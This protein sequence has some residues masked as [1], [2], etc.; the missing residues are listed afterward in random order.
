MSIVSSPMYYNSYIIL[1]ILFLVTVHGWILPFQAFRNNMRAIVPTVAV[2]V[3]GA[4]QAS[5][6]ANLLEKSY[7]RLNP[8]ERLSTTPLFFVC[9]SGGNPYLQEDIQAG[10]PSQRIIVYFMSSEDARDY[11]NEMVQGSPHNVNDFRIMTTSMSKVMTKIQ[12]R[13]QSRKV[14]RYPMSTIW[15]IQPSS[16]QSENADMLLEASKARSNTGR[17]ASV[18]VFHAKGMAVLEGS[19]KVISPYYFAYEDLVDDWQELETRPGTGAKVKDG[20]QAEIA[21][22]RGEPRVEVL[23]LG[24]V[25]CAA[26]TDDK[27]ASTVGIVPPRR[28]IEQVK[29][30]YRRGANRR[31]FEKAKIMRSR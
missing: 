22:P 25:M 18:P 3:L 17:I 23:D 16:R 31:E 7:H 8:Y 26:R 4:P 2:G 5:Q 20:P 10:D 1:L 29:R 14:G 19:G 6:A 13:K 11:L 27:S 30:F 28:E 9:N 12:T 24:D 21:R 15:R